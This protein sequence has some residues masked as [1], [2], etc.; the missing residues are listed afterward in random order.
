MVYMR[1][2]EGFGNQLFQYAFVRALQ[3][4]NNVD[5]RLCVLPDQGDRTIRKYTLDKL[6]I[7]IPRDKNFEKAALYMEK[8]NI[9]KTMFQM[10][11][12][13]LGRCCFIEEKEVGYNED[14]K[15]LRENCYLS[16]WFQNEDYF[17]DF[18]DIIKKEIRPK[19][20]IKISKELRDIFY[21]ETTVSVHIRRGDYRRYNNLLSENYYKMSLALIE[22]QIQDAFYVVFSDDLKWVKEHIEFGEKVY[23]V[24]SDNTL[25]DYEELFIMS[26]CRHNIIANST[27]SWWGAWLNENED[28]LVIGPKKW[29]ANSKINIMP[30]AWMKL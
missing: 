4:R 6:K 26:R 5:A 12:G 27:F 11:A 3:L 7:T 22:T 24:N 30:D 16:G 9:Y 13:K 14:L 25:E 15:A 18:A 29:F 21:N 19:K 2:W 23:F 20:K 8:H 28:K 17:K 1:I 10:I